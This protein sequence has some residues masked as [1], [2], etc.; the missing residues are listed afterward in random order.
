MNSVLEILGPL[1]ITNEE[2]SGGVEPLSGLQIGSLIY[3]PGQ[4]HVQ[5]LVDLRVYT[6]TIIMNDNIV[7]MTMMRKTERTRICKFFNGEG[8]VRIFDLQ[9]VL[10]STCF[11]PIHGISCQFDYCR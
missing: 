4:M 6:P 9:C 5:Y 7:I 1:R 11:L 2:L 3:W 8:D 10:V